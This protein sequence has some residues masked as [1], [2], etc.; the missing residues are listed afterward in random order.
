MKFNPFEQLDPETAAIRA[1]HRYRNLPGL[2]KLEKRRALEIGVLLNPRNIR[3]STVPRLKAVAGNNIKKLDQAVAVSQI[4]GL[5]QFAFMGSMTAVASLWLQRY[6]RD[7]YVA[8]A[9]LVSVSIVTLIDAGYRYSKIDKNYVPSWYKPSLG[10]VLKFVV[11][12]GI[13]AVLV[14]IYAFNR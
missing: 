13:L 14:A 2:T 9:A 8:S 3:T 10:Y 1:T 5:I 12:I 7:I 4:G 11:A 6:S